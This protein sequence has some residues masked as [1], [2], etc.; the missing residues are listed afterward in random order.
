MLFRSE[1]PSDAG[2]DNVYNI[3]VTASD[4]TLTNSK[5]VAITVTNVNETPT[6]IALSSSSVAENQSSGTTV[7]TFST[8]DPDTGNTFT[9]TLVSGTGDTDNA[10]FTIESGVLKTAASFD[11]ETKS[12]YSIRVRSTDQGGLSTDKTFTISVTDVNESPSVTSGSTASFA[13]NATGTV[14][15]AIATDPEGTTLSYS[16]SGT[17]ASLFDINSSTEI[18][19]AHV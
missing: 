1:L 4:G 12:S 6:D 2:S 11:Y 8:T 7:G 19:R 13:E 17:D 14:Y 18:G 3:T 16:I 5:A 9:Y 10:S 15:T